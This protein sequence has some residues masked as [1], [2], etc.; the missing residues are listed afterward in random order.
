MDEWK[1]KVLLIG[2]G[3]LEQIVKNY[4]SKEKIITMQGF[5]DVEAKFENFQDGL[6]FSIIC[7]SS[8]SEAEALEAAQLIKCQSPKT[9]LFYVSQK[10]E[11]FAPKKFIKNGFNDAFLMPFDEENLKFK[12]LDTISADALANRTFRAVRPIDMPIGAESTF[13]TFVFLPLN[14]KYV[15]YIPS[16]T[17]VTQ[18]KMQRLERS[19]H[20]RM[21]LDQ[22][23][24]SKFFEHTANHLIKMNATSNTMTETEKEEKLNTA[25][26]SLVFDIFDASQDE[27]IDSG[28]EMLVT[29][30]KIVSNYITHGSEDDWYAMLI[31]NM[32]GSGGGYNRV[33]SISTYAALMGIGLGL[34]S[35]EDLAI[36]AMMCDLALSDVPIELFDVDPKTWP[37]EYKKI[38]ET[39]PQ[40]SI[41]LI[42]KKKLVVSSAAE[43]AILQH[44]ERFDGKGFPSQRHGHSISQE[45]QILSVALQ[46][47]DLTVPVPG[48]AKKTPFQAI[49]EIAK[50]GS[51]SPELGNNLIKMF[52]DKHGS[53]IKKGKSA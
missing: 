4:L 12:V 14:N 36:A 20:G 44:H 10:R 42:K 11:G 28:K 38:Y 8:L 9:P 51:I 13:D 22:K 5:K 53:N 1:G 40:Q 6:F 2:T 43:K 52:S 41:N 7:D 34:G 39:H 32:G 16:G 33:S 37:E 47:Y 50:N 23:D 48:K 35:I 19:N 46:L 15:K 21:F 29:C 18:E 27:S 45:A 26:R 24:M 49:E 3:F 31:K 30:Q 17:E 25:V